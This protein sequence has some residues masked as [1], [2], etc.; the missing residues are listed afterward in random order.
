MIKAI[1]L[2]MDNTLLINPDKVF[3]RAFL[4]V[5]EQHFS[6]A[7][8]E[9]AVENFRDA[10]QAMSRE[11]AGN[12][13]NR[14]LTLDMLGGEVDHANATLD[15]FYSN[16]YPQ[17]E[18]CVSTVEGASEL[19]Y[20]LKDMDYE[21]VIAT[22]PLYPETA[23][24][25]R[26]T[27]AGL[28][29]DDDLYSLITSA[30]TMHFAKPDP[31]YYAEILGRLGIEPDEAIMVGDSTK[32]DIIPAGTVGLQTF[33]TGDNGL[34]AFI[35]DLH[36]QL[37]QASGLQ[38]HPDMIEPQ[39][40][41]NIGALFGFVD[42]V[43]DHFWHQRPDPEEWSI[44]QILCH[45]VT[46]EEENERKRLVTILQK[47]NPFITQPEQPGP[48]I[49]ECADNGLLIAKDFM[50]TRQK[51]IEFIQ[52]LTDSDWKRPARHSIFG[53]TTMLEMAYFTAQHD[54]LHLKQLCQTIGRCE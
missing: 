13:T 10:I 3:A 46:S 36:N 44:I 35:A 12:R 22:N 2:D 18:H 1:L 14:Q 45:L 11:Q 21:V 24:R 26:M 27:W 54:R 48:D 19:I 31:A 6:A 4:D 32:N 38:L 30:D 47:E 49:E 29:L 8:F 37:K 28:P 51:T 53:L 9:N 50:A 41:G 25:Q 15:S 7:G 42:T 43:Q 5:F 34:Q 40:R 39:F 20:Q 16:V 52:S 33:H 17:L 23:I